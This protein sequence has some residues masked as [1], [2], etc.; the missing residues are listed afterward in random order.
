MGEAAEDQQGKVQLLP[1]GL[2]L[3]E[4]EPNS[5]LLPVTGRGGDPLCPQ[6]EAIIWAGGEE[7]LSALAS[8][9]RSHFQDEKTEAQRG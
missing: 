6:G 4:P 5:S 1:H 8:Y 2:S 3:T 7:K 9:Y